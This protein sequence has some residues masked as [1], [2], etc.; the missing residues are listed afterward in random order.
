MRIRINMM[1]LN[2]FGETYSYGSFVCSICGIFQPS[3]TR[4]VPN[5]VTY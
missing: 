3:G 5:D 2:S 1:A 4:N